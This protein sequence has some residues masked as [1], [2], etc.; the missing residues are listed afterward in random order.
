LIQEL[1]QSNQKMILIRNQGDIRVAG[2]RAMSIYLSN[3]LP[4]GGRETNWL[5]TM[6]HTEGLLFIVFIAPERSFPGYESTFRKML[7]SVRVIR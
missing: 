5:V 4:L 3:D 2:A 6:A 1:R 7:R